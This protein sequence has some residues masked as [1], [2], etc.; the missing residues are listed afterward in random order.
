M[1]I[2]L[3]IDSGS[4]ILPA[5]A[6]SMNITHIPMSVYFG[7]QEYKDAVTLSH[8]EFYEKLTE[9][10]Q[11]PT[12]S[13]ITPA[14]YEDV[15]AELTANGDTVLVITISSALSGTYQSACIAADSFP[16]LVYVVDSLNVCVGTRILA[17]RALELIDKG[18]DIDTI[19]AMLN[20]EKKQIRVMAV[21]DTLEYLKKGGRISA[22]VALAGNLLSIKPVV[23]VEEGAVV[24]AGKA[25][26]SKN[27]CNLLRT[28]I[29]K[30]KG[31]DFTRPYNV[32]YSGL[33]DTGVLAYLEDHADL[34]RT[35]VKEIIPTTVGCTIGTHVGPG[36]IAVGF[37][38]KE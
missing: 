16:G 15:F 25:R 37:F 13:Q 11:L 12:T 36:A 19:T 28:M 1:A 22:A 35:H 4:D 26:G 14:S 30:G 5:E 20:M 31:I 24:M 18:Y 33:S 34:W 6:A 23:A 2:R 3:V 21:L 8:R 38:E 9:S 10:S 32:A 7:D 29:E 27:S 17:E